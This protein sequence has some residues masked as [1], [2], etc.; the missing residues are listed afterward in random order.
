M[1]G[2]RTGSAQSEPCQRCHRPVRARGQIRSGAADAASADGGRV[3]RF[4]WLL[5]LLPAVAGAP[6]LVAAADSSQG[7]N[8]MQLGA[9]CDGATDDAGA[10]TKAIERAKVDGVPVLLPAA[11]CAYGAVLNLDGV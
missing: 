11:T 3:M 1:L 8:P 9:K 6:S 5:A 10:I 2:T 4:A 7:V